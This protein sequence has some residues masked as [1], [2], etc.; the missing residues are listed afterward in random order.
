MLR[1]MDALPIIPA[2]A[3]SFGATY[4]LGKVCLMAFVGSLEQSRSERRPATQ[5]QDIP[6][7]ALRSADT[8]VS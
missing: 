4:Y 2:I 8:L 5:R 1:S 6:S 3:L 7:R